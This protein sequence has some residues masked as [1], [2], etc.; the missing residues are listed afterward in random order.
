MI[1]ADSG[2]RATVV[3]SMLSTIQQHWHSCRT[4]SSCA[5]GAQHQPSG[6]ECAERLPSTHARGSDASECR[7]STAA[8]LHKHSC[9]GCSWRSCT[10]QL[11]IRGDS[12]PSRAHAAH[13]MPLLTS[14]WSFATKPSTRTPAGQGLSAPCGQQDHRGH[15]VAQTGPSLS[16][17][18]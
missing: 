1:A 7:G 10:P 9:R 18:S 17:Q 16:S 2:P 11:S 12:C 3:A 8:C 5:T 13:L 6:L 4:A 15:A 14:P